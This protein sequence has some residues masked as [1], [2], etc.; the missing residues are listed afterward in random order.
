MLGDGLLRRS[1]GLFFK[2]LQL[3]GYVS[4]RIYLYTPQTILHHQSLQL[5]AYSLQLL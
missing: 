5:T 3:L 2:H 4:V 1:W